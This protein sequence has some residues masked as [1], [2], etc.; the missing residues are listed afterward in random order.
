MSMPGVILAVVGLIV[1]VVAV[2]NHFAHFLLT[3][4]AH[5]DIYIGVVGLIVLAVGGYMATRKAA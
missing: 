1:V 3:G 5:I 2:I 4:T